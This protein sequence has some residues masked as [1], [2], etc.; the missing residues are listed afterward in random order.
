MVVHTPGRNAQAVAE[1]VLGLML[2]LARHIPQANHYVHSN[3]WEEPAEPYTAFRGRELAGAALGVV[4]WGTSAGGWPAW[5]AL[6]GCGC[7]PTIPT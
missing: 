6:S 3:R 1:L 4:A 2:S 5:A 7:S